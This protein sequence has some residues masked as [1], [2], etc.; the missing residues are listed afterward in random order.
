MWVVTDQN[1][2]ELSL[3]RKGDALGVR[4]DN[5]YP[6]A[7]NINEFLTN[8]AKFLKTPKGVATLAAVVILPDSL[9]IGG[10][11]AVSALKQKGILKAK[12][13]KTVKHSDYICHY[14]VLGMKWGVRRTPEELGYK[15]AR[16]SKVSNFDRWGKDSDHNI[17]WVTGLSGSGKSTTARSLLKE[18]DQLVSL[19]YYFGGF[20]KKEASKGQN[21]NFNRYLDGKQ[22][23]WRDL[24]LETKTTNRDWSKVDNFVKNLK[25]FAKEEFKKGNKVIVDGVQ[26]YQRFL[27][28]NPF[29]GLKGQPLMIVGSDLRRSAKQAAK[30][31][32]KSREEVKDYISNYLANANAA[33]KELNS[34][35]N[36]M[37]LEKG[38]KFVDEYFKRR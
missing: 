16:K 25:G 8:G 29:E 23:D 2:S 5:P 36:Q 18:N 14:G 33:E 37:N 9:I 24:F 20:S 30:R 6:G 38:R 12:V 3:R 10:A 15:N 35:A 26:I 11:A 4:K 7:K 19:D 31:D 34:L 21:K 13:P 32:T 22:P 28:D 27:F 1:G 17:L